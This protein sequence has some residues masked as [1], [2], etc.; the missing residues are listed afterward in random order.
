VDR[1][2]I[3]YLKKEF[4]AGITQP[5]FDI[6]I[7]AN[8]QLTRSEV[9]H[10]WNFLVHRHYLNTRFSQRNLFPKLVQNYPFIYK[11]LRRHGYDGVGI[12]EDAWPEMFLFN[13][14]NAVPLSAHFY[15]TEGWRT[16]WIKANL[17]LSEPLSL[18]ELKELQK[19]ERRRQ[20]AFEPWG[21]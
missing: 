20:E 8:K 9:A 14:S 18:A 17:Q 2:A 3:R 15:S 7:P 11:H 1:R 10:L 13:P 5:N 6:Q 4:G 16:D 19:T 12:R 21:A